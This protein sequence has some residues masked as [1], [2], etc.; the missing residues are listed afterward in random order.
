MKFTTV[1]LALGAFLAST[2]LTEAAAIDHAGPWSQIHHKDNIEHFKIYAAAKGSDL[3]SAKPVMSKCSVKFPKNK[4]DT[5]DQFAQG[6]LLEFQRLGAHTGS[7]YF[8][9]KVQDHRA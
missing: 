5:Y 2:T 8:E 6:G 1:F 9:C 4:A 3:R 7:N